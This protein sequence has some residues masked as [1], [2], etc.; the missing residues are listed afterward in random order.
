MWMLDGLRRWWGKSWL[1][2]PTPGMNGCRF[3]GQTGH[4]LRAIRG[5]IRPVGDD[6]DDGGD[7][8]GGDFQ[9]PRQ[10]CAG[11]DGTLCVFDD[12]NDVIQVYDCGGS[13]VRCIDV[14]QVDDEHGGWYKQIFSEGLNSEKRS[15]VLAAGGGGEILIRHRDEKKLM[16]L[17]REGRGI[18]NVDVFQG[19]VLSVVADADGQLFVL[20][21]HNSVAVLS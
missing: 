4:F 7:S 15:H 1:P 16:V 21:S 19:R 3:C 11:A 10:V 18:Q 17:D 14:A 13:F 5:K 6:S 20:K 9:Q 8:E 2:L 12:A